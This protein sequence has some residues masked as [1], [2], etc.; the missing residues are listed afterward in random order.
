MLSVPAHTICSSTIVITSQRKLATSWWAKAFPNISLTYLKRYYK[1]KSCCL[2]TIH[3]QYC[4]SS[5][6]MLITPI[7]T[8]II[9]WLD[10]I[11]T[12]TVSTFRPIGQALGPLIETLS[13]SASA[14]F[15]V[16]QRFV[17]ARIQRE[18]SP[19]YQLL[20]TA[21]EEAR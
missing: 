7:H 2:A 5:C 14:G 15:T 21:I 6:F 1:R 10:D 16:G 11:V 17:E 4:F 19:E 12:Q 3:M 8:S 13:N 9:S 20:N 18:A